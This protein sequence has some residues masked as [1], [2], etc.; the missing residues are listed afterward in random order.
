MHIGRNL[1]QGVTIGKILAG[2]PVLFWSENNGDL[3]VVVELSFD[4]GRE[5]VETNNRL[6]CF[7]VS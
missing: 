1:Y 4:H 6:F 7:A 3:T 2:Q 5:F